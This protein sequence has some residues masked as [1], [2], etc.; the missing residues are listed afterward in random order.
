MR[1]FLSLLFTDDVGI[2]KTGRLSDGPRVTQ[3]LLTATQR[4]A[5][6]VTIFAVLS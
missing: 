3:G 4:Q 6:M 2:Q 5:H 1:D